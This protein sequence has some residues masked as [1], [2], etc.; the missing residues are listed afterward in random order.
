MH[1]GLVLPGFVATE[2]FP[3]SELTARPA[4]RWIVSRPEVVAEAIMQAGPLGRAERYVPR[5]YGLLAALRTL[6]P[7]IIRRSV[8]G[9]AFTTRTRPGE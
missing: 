1:V 6:A 7:A 4:T 9:G 5:P 8:R 2:G 3:A